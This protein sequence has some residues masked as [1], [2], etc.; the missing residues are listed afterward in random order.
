MV[1]Y[2]GRLT[3][4]YENWVSVTSNQIV[5]NWVKGYSVSFIKTPIQK[6]PPIES[7]FSSRETDLMSTEIN[8][9]LRQGSI[10]KCDRLPDQFLSRIFLADRPREKEIYFKPKRTKQ[11]RRCSPF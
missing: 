3:L 6:Q 11:V 10:A 8:N 4:F 5:L 9:L 1:S 2:A 7:R